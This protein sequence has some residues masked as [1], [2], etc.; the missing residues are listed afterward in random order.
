MFNLHRKNFNAGR[1]ETHKQTPFFCNALRIRLHNNRST[2]GET[3]SADMVI[4]PIT[5]DRRTIVDYAI[6][7]LRLFRRV[8]KNELRN[9]LPAPLVSILTEF[10]L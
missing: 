2:C 1:G 3:G 5:N 6:I 10:V 9:E 7:V 8:I 4:I